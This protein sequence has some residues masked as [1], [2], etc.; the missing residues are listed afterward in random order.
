MESNTFISA[1]ISTSIKRFGRPNARSSQVVELWNSEQSLS[2][3]I[4]L[5]FKYDGKTKFVAEQ[6]NIRRN[7]LIEI[8]QQKVI[9]HITQCWIHDC[10]GNTALLSQK[11]GLF[12]YQFFPKTLRWHQRFEQHIKTLEINAENSEAISRILS[13][14]RD[15]RM[16]VGTTL[17]PAASR[18]HK[19]PLPKSDVLD[20]QEEPDDPASISEKITKLKTLRYGS[21]MI[22][23]ET[24]AGKGWL[25]KKIYEYIYPDKKQPFIHINC[26]HLL[27]SAVELFGCE[28]GAFT[29]AIDKKGAFEKIV[30]GGLLFLDE[31]DSLSIEVQLKLLL[32]LG[33]DKMATRV[34]STKPIYINRFTLITATNQDLELL[35]RER[36]FRQDL[37]GR[38]SQPAIRLKS[39]KQ[40]PQKV[41]LYIIKELQDHIIEN[42]FEPLYGLCLRDKFLLNEAQIDILINSGFTYNVRS[43]RKQITDYMAQFI[44]ENQKNLLTPFSL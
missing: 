4:E 36:K 23:G 44:L 30:Q 15:E 32:V 2:R 5:Y 19:L 7:T 25:A 9:P 3:L 33:E 26:A 34:G 28:R 40:Q 42:D 16:A 27:S 37:L 39:W 10:Q 21:M 29:D 8:I 41:K 20:Q 6:L 31:I 13:F 43:V 1:S 35:S 38:I 24:G 17:P 14:L 22:L 11:L 18:L 12:K